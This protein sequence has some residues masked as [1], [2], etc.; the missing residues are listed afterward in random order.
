MLKTPFAPLAA[1]NQTVQ[2]PNGRVHITHRPG[3]DRAVVLLHGF[4][5][6]SRIYDRLIPHLAPRRVVALDWLGYCRSE[7]AT[8]HPWDIT[9]HQR[10]LRAVLD[11]LELKRVALV[12]HDASGPDAIDFALSEPS[13]VAH[14]ILL[15]TFYGRARPCSACPR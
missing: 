9:D 2:G 6:D 1:T 5:D 11:S 13:R 3:E 14:L 4:P 8:P 12:G 15:N 7:R 10:T